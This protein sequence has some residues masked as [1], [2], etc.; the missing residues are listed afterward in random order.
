LD[1]GRNRWKLSDY[2]DELKFRKGGKTLVTL[3]ARDGFFKV[4]VIL[5][6]EERAVYEEKQAGFS[7]AIRKN[8]DDTHTYHD[9]KWLGIDVSDSLLIDDII[10]LLHIKR[11]P[12]RKEKELSLDGCGR[13]GNCCGACL[14]YV[15]NNENGKQG[16]LLFQEMDWRCYHS[17]GEE[18]AD[19]SGVICPGCASMCGNKTVDCLKKKGFATCGECD[20]RHCN[21]PDDVHIA[22][23]DPGKCNLGL[24][25][26]E[27]TR[28]V[29][30]Y[31]GKERFDRAKAIW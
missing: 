26:E 28:C 22:D 11:K 31:C 15:K 20:Y 10:N 23:F 24:T 12:N 4:V 19:Y 13:C 3:Y 17:E 18:Q 29:I 5:G 27:I 7:D 6:K 1:S 21:C 30:P 14:L 8:Y 9:G 25:A 2:R 16:N